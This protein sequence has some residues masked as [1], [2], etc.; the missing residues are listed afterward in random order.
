MTLLFLSALATFP[1]A[2]EDL[3]GTYS[4]THELPLCHLI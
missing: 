3:A 4:P 1:G 2:R